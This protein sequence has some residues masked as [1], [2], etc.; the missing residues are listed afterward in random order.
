MIRSA[1]TRSDDVETV[2]R[3]VINKTGYRDWLTDD[4]SEEGHERAANI[5][6]LVVA[7][8][9]FDN[10][11][12]EDGGLERYLEQAALV[13]DSDAWDSDANFVSLM[14]LHAAKG[15][16]FPCV[17][18][19]GLEDGLLPHERSAKDPD[20]L[21]EE[22]RLLF[23]GITRAMEELQLSRCLSRFRRGSF[24]PCIASSFLMELPRD[25]MAVFE[26][27]S[28]QIYDDELDDVP[29]DVDPWMHDG[30]ESGYRPEEIDARGQEDEEE[31]ETINESL[32]GY[33]PNGFP[34][35]MTGADF[36]RKQQEHVAIRP[37]L[38][39]SK[40]A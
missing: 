6:E 8:Q 15:L 16:E 35:I 30:V 11:H 2:M 25:A 24:W 13:S 17:F 18:I 31:P 36:E 39:C 19:V 27:N 4:G 33:E 22:R 12:P 20:Q 1:S 10:E 3:T 38:P 7:A 34:R 5:D 37:T 32:T 14:T 21:E 28:T 26:P 23:V 29:F 9:E 40:L